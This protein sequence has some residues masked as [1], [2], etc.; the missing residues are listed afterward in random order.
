MVSEATGTLTSWGG[1]G[2]V[3]VTERAVRAREAQR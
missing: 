2:M 3:M 1:R